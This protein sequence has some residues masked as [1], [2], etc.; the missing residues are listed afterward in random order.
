VAAYKSKQAQLPSCISYS[1]QAGTPDP[2]PGGDPDATRCIPVG[3]QRHSASETFRPRGLVVR[4]LLRLCPGHVPSSIR[5]T[6]PHPHSFCT[7]AQSPVGAATPTTH[8]HHPLRPR[9]GF[10]ARCPDDIINEVTSSELAPLLCPAQSSHF[11]IE[12]IPFQGVLRFL[13]G[14]RSCKQAQADFMFLLN[15]LKTIKTFFFFDLSF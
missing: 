12:G 1:C 9:N 8:S 13:L 3:L 10:T 6:P 5:R 2:R 7:P 11:H 14:V 4:T 15:F